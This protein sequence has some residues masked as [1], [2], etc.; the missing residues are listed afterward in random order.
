MICEEKEFAGIKYCLY[1]PENFDQT[2]KYPTVFFTHGAGTRGDD[3]GM[4]KKHSV[5]LKLTEHALGCVIF[6]PQCATDTW[7]DKFESLI[8][9]AKHAYSQPYVDRKRFYGSGVSMGGY[10]MYQLMSSVPDLFAAGIICCGG[11]MY[12]NAARLKNIALRL[13]HGEKDEVVY[14]EESRRIYSALKSCGGDVELF[15]Y[16]ECDHD[17]WSKTYANDDNYDWL[18]SK[19]KL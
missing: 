11:G 7:F 17:C 19:E 10:G 8:A 13:F 6:A 1:K 12:W 2:K 3:L 16:P 14:P 9:L 4:I 15:I 18:L 5:I